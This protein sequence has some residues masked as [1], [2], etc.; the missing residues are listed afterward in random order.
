VIP[1]CESALLCEKQE[2]W[3]RVHLR[4]DRRHIKDDDVHRLRSIIKKK[5]DLEMAAT[6]EIYCI[7]IRTKPISY[8]CTGTTSGTYN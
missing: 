1:I 2:G 6:D 4:E 3:H 7:A 8:T 5:L